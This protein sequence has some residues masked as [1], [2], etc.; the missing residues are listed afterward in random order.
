MPAS[1]H[2][3]A[4]SATID[5]DPVTTATT[6][7]ARAMRT[8]AP[9]AT[10]TVS[11]LSLP[12]DDAVASEAAG[13]GGRAGLGHGH[14]LS[15]G[16]GQ[17]PFSDGSGAACAAC[18]GAARPRDRAGRDVA[19]VGEGAAAQAQAAA[20]D[21]PVE[22]ALEPLQRCDLVVEALAPVA[23]DALPVGLGGGPVVGQPGELVADLARW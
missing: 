23:R 5:A 3:W 10:S 19:G 20:A 7:L 14:S 6:D 4:A 22:A 21:A 18:R 16:H 11:R 8:L 12:V 2:E 17:H 13:R 1:D 15:P 9:S